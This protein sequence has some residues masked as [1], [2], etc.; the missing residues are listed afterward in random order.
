MKFRSIAV[1]ALALC[2]LGG[3]AAQPADTGKSWQTMQNVSLD[4]GFDTVI[5]LIEQT[6]DPDG[7][8]DHFSRLC[9]SFRYY[10][11][12]YD[13][14]ND[15]EGIA[16]LKTVNEQAGIAPVK[17]DPELIELLKKGKE[18]YELS[19]GAFDITMGSL[20]R[21]WH[22][23]RTEGMALNEHKQLG[24]LPSEEE[25]QEAA[26]HH[27][28]EYLVIDEENSTVFIT[29]PDVQLDVGGIAKGYATEQTAKMLE[30][31]NVTN[32]A[33][34]AG[35]NNRTLGSKRD[36]STWN[37]GIQN[38]DD[39]G[40]LFV[41]QISGTN[42][43]VTSGDYERFYVAEDGH[44]YQHII[45][46]QTLRPATR[47]RSVTIITPDSGDADCLSTAL[48]VLSIED[49]EAV[50]DAYR[51]KTGNSAEAIWILPEN[52]S[53]NAAHMHKMP[54]Y[55]IVYTEGLENCLVFN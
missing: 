17:V 42:S 32:A 21:V 9:D 55:N 27:G 49:G 6:D 35:G 33:I 39:Q 26:S 48:T 10:N 13:I 52:E 18:F 50:L 12:L 11:N 37:V 3:C 45:D 40:S 53:V 34:N 5:T 43:F 30:D 16:N 44:R 24:R 31:L 7:F 36:G 46:P 47:Y 28:L 38:P 4:A 54:G 23:Y 51:S 8:S 19:N 1:P 22:E 2:L 15:Y 29:D 41:V 25:L 20:L 14:Y